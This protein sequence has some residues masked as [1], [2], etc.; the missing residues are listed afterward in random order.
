MRA[1]IAS[2]IFIAICCLALWHFSSEY[3]VGDGLGVD[4]STEVEA[5][6]QHNAEEALALEQAA[7][8]VLSRGPDG[9]IGASPV[10]SPGDSKEVVVRFLDSFGYPIENSDGL[11]VEP[12]TNANELESVYLTRDNLWLFSFL[13]KPQDASLGTDVYCRIRLK[14]NAWLSIEI[15]LDTVE[16]TLDS[17]LN[18]RLLPGGLWDG[19]VSGR[20][21]DSAG[22]PIEGVEVQL[23]EA[24]TGSSHFVLEQTESLTTGGFWLSFD[25][26]EESP[27]LRLL[28]P[29]YERKEI[30]LGRGSQLGDIVLTKGDPLD[31]SILLPGEIAGGRIVF[32]AG[33][34]RQVAD[35]ADD[36]SFEIFGISEGQWDV[37]F[38]RNGVYF[39]VYEGVDPWQASMEIDL[40]SRSKW[41]NF[42]T[43]DQEA[44]A[45]SVVGELVTLV[46]GRLISIRWEGMPILLPRE[47]SSPILRCD[48]FM[49]TPLNFDEGKGVVHLRQ[50]IEVQIRIPELSQLDE[51]DEVYLSCVEEQMDGLQPRR[52][53]FEKAGDV[54][55]G[56]L[57]QRGIY[58]VVAVLIRAKVPLHKQKI[59]LTELG[60]AKK[61]TIQVTR[62]RALFEMQLPLDWIE[63]ATDATED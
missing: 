51:G 45:L 16:G 12:V 25:L 49:D 2:V 48:G 40:Q 13:R 29:G 26:A 58:E 37:K 4:S 61:N 31:G 35:V 6:S 19:M 15:D 39:D 56:K 46:R 1:S 17:P 14:G 62:E 32:V 5:A 7:S 41:I 43:L 33:D 3:S 10:L 8:T 18:V 54:F 28:C 53:Q 55:I 36:G 57:P 63:V 20:I 22:T 50:A 59:D 38:L 9:Q 23:V 27:G 21:L 24:L 60:S 30:L 47:A 11:L 52:F 44:E 42:D 34:E